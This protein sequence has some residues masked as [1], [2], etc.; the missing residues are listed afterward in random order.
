MCPQYCCSHRA[1][2]AV[3][4]ICITIVAIAVVCVTVVVVAMEGRCPRRRLRTQVAVSQSDPLHGTESADIPNKTNITLTA[5]SSQWIAR[6]KRRT[7]TEIEVTH[8][9]ASS[10]REG[11]LLITAARNSS[12]ERANA[13]FTLR[14]I[15]TAKVK[16]KWGAHGGTVDYDLMSLLDNFRRGPDDNGACPGTHTCCDKTGHNSLAVT[17]NPGVLEMRRNGH[18]E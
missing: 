10:T 1:Q 17:N 8:T 3:A 16:L 4:V 5:L 2:V 14:N 9:S 18:A 6:L 13:A 11:L 12:R 15:S 7:S